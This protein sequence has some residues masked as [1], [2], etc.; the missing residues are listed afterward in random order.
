MRSALG[1][2]LLGLL[3]E[4]PSYGYEL[5]LRFK[6]TYGDNLT[7]SKGA[8]VYRLLELLSGHALIE[9][10]PSEA[11]AASPH[12]H[13][14]GPHYRATRQGV[15]A[16]QEWL[17]SQMEYERQRQ[18]LFARQLAMLEPGAALTVIERWEGECLEEV[19][20]PDEGE[21]ES[22]TRSVAQRLADADERLAL[23][24]RLSWIAYARSE[25]KTIIR[26]RTGA[27]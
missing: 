10:V 25:L 15:R 27:P 22:E 11:A 1:W 6:R 19:E 21:G 4:Q 23:Q 5:Q 8:H 17:V 12:G 24:V 13:R 9:E 20:E 26:E 2:A 7:L 16:Y 18:R 14:S 3:I